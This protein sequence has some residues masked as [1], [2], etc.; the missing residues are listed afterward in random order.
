M[1]SKPELITWKQAS[2]LVAP[3]NPEIAA[4]I[5]ALSPSDAYPLIRLTKTFGDSLI[6]VGKINISEEFKPLLSYSDIPLLMSLDKHLEVYVENDVRVIP[7]NV[8]GEGQLLGLFETVDA[9]FR[10]D[11]TAPWSVSVGSRTLCALA[12]ITDQLKY[13]KLLI[14]YSNLSHQHRIT[15]LEDHWYFF[16]ALAKSPEFAADWSTDILIF[17][18][19][20]FDT[21]K[22]DSK[23]WQNLYNYVYAQAW[24]TAKFALFKINIE[25]Q[26]EKFIASIS[27]KRLKPNPYIA[28][29]IKHLCMMSLGRVP[30]FVPADNSQKLMPSNTFKHILV[31]E[32]G[33]S[34]YTPTIMHA[35][36]QNTVSEHQPVYYSLAYP[37]LMGG[38][39]TASSSKT[40]VMDLN[41]IILCMDAILKR[42]NNAFLHQVAFDYFHVHEDPNKMIQSSSAIPQYD[43]RFGQYDLSYSEKLFPEA[44]Q[45]WNGC[46]AIKKTS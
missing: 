13:Q 35:G 33:L 29:T 34:K 7:L 16:K 1:E 2:S 15:R 46:I 37:T 9:L 39:P 18:S 24:Q 38:S 41:D 20:W 30:G 11:S 23:A 31:E 45:F 12:K 21:Q 27:N 4:L 25:L 43:P 44:S 5:D 6:E 26:W 42:D 17:T 28:D 10:Y 14:K 19:P 3:I 32:Y 8:L 22:N 36:A 40:K